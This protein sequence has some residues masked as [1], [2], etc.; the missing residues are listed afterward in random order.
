MY[1]AHDGPE[2]ALNKASTSTEMCNKC[3]YSC[4]IDLL[5]NSDTEQHLADVERVQS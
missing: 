2:E 5:K 3:L 4:K 1:E